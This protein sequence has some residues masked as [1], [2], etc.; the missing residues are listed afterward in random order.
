[1]SQPVMSTNIH[2]IQSSAIQ[3]AL[4]YIIY[5]VP[6]RGT[7]IL[8]VGEERE[9]DRGLHPPSF[10]TSL[11][12]GCGSCGSTSALIYVRELCVCTIQYILAK[13]H[14]WPLTLCVHKVHTVFAVC[15]CVQFFLVKFNYALLLIFILVINI[16]STHI[17]SK[18]I[19][20]TNFYNFN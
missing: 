6:L 17:Q 3:P 11:H 13:D 10:L 5:I 8:R 1:M 12:P 15:L 16:Y 20:L 2:T 19:N 18:E 9:V 14:M 4:H 7:F